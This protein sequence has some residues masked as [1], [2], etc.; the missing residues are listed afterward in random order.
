MISA[1]H[2]GRNLT[3]MSP[4]RIGKTGLIKNA[5]Y[6][7]H[8]NEPKAAC[9]Y[10]DIFSTRNQ[11]NLINVLGQAIFAAT[12]TPLDKAITILSQC[13]PVV[14]VDQ[15]SG[16]TTLSFVSRKRHGGIATFVYTILAKRT[17]HFCWQPSTTH[18]GD[19]PFCTKTFLSKH[20]D[21]ES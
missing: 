1:L 17:L 9:I 15:F 2:N 12:K 16:T 13:R 5:F 20:T 8:E 4:R 7:I 19:I 6:H 18:V 10:A 3:L 11:Q 14:G 21:D